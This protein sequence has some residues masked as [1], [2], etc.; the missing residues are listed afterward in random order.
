MKKEKTMSSNIQ[1]D[2]ISNEAEIVNLINGLEELAKKELVKT[3]DLYMEDLYLF[4]AVDK[5]LKLIDTFLFALKDRNITVLASLTRIQMDCVLRTYATTLVSDSDAFCKKIL[6]NNVPVSNEVDVNKKRLTDKYLCDSLSKIL[7]L[8]LYEL[9]QKV[10]G[11]VHFSSNSFYNIARIS[12]DD[13]ISMLISKHNRAEDE[14]TYTRLSIELANH[15]YYFG[16]ILITVVIRSWLIQKE[17]M[18]E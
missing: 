10:C 8:P 3:Q 6:L 15:F 4:A 13:G 5:S 1:Y 9:Y 2:F 18:A 14:E 12:G 17:G 16:K 11:Y 7:H